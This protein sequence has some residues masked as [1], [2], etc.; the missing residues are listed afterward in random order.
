MFHNNLLNKFCTV[1]LYLL[2]YMAQLQ[3]VNWRDWKK[4]QL[5]SPVVE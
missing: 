3:L 4:T 1:T 2:V 5:C